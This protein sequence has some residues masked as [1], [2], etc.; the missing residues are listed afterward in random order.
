MVATEPRLRP[1]GWTASI[2]AFG[3]PAGLLAVLVWVVIPVLHARGT[4][5]VVSFFLLGLP[6]LL[7]LVATLLAY[8]REGRRLT[9]PAFRDRM[10]LGPVDRRGVAWILGLS[11]AGV[12]LYLGGARLVDALFPEAAFPELVGAV[13][14]DP[15]RA[16]GRLARRPLPRRRAAPPPRG[17]RLRLGQPALPQP[18]ARADRARRPERPRRDPDRLGD[19]GLNPRRGVLRDLLPGHGAVCTSGEQVHQLVAAGLAR[20]LEVVPLAEDPAVV[21]QGGDPRHR[22]PGRRLEWRHGGPLAGRA[23]IPRARRADRRARRRDERLRQPPRVLEAAGGGWQRPVPLRQP[24]HPDPGVRGRAVPG[25]PGIGPPSPRPA[26][27]RSP[28][29]G[30]QAP[31]SPCS[32]WGYGDTSPIRARSSFQRGSWRSLWKSGSISTSRTPS[33]RWA[34]ARSSQRNASSDSPRHA[35]TAAIRVA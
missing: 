31:G 6:F 1:M 12:A 16:V 17:A 2:L 30:P 7:M 10:R 29:R 15:R 13:L 18:V 34:R 11:V 21:G 5:P 9:W 32:R 35:W 26:A 22:L 20:R 23:G 8:R 28:R 4:A 24:A 19:A 27:S 3:V 25:S 14:G 33:S